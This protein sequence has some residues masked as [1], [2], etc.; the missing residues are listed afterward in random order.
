[1][2]RFGLPFQYLHK[3]IVVRLVYFAVMMLNVPIN[4]K[5]CQTHSPREVVTGRRF[6]VERHCRCVFGE[7]V[8]ASEDADVTNDMKPRTEPCIALG[9]SRNEQGSI[10]CFQVRNAKLV[11]CCTF[12]P[13]PMPDLIIRAMNAWGKLSAKAKCK[14]SMKQLEFLNRNKEKFSWDNEELDLSEIKVLPDLVTPH[15]DRDSQEWDWS[16]ILFPRPLL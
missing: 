11:Q 1:M 14:A 3:L 9:W 10:V 7:Y 4:D 15:T 2:H 12:E 6:N 13:L 8:E 5:G 16:L